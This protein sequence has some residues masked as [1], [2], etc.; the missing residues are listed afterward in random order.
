MGKDRFGGL[1]ILSSSYY[2]YDRDFKA[3][4]TLLEHRQNRGYWLQVKIN[5][6]YREDRVSQT[7]KRQYFR[8]KE[9]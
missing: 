2:S 8:T 3:F 6:D 4:L 1:S 7:R 5:I 9:I